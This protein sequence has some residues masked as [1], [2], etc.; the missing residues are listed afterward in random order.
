MNAVTN[1]LL[2]DVMHREQDNKQGELDVMQRELDVMRQEQD[3]MQRELDVMEQELDVMQIKYVGIRLQ[4]TSARFNYK[5]DS[6]Y[7]MASLVYK[8][9]RNLDERQSN[10]ADAQSI[11]LIKQD[12]IDLKEYS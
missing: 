5:P 4:K 12:F 10:I 1:D 6:I 11:Q 9:R 3:N 7:R 2:L 8:S